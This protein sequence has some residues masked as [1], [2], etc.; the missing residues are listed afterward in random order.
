MDTKRLKVLILVNDLLRG[1][2]QRI[3]ADIAH[4]IDTDRFEL[5]VAYLKPF[6]IF[7]TDS[8]SLLSEIEAGHVRI[9]CVGGRQKASFSEFFKLLKLLRDEKPDV[10][11]TF[12]PYASILG[13]VAG[14]LAGVR[15]IVSTQCNASVSY[16]R[17]IYWLDKLTLP[18][19]GAWT[20]VTEGIE[21]EYGGSIAHYSDDAWSLGRRHF[22][23][24]SAVNV[25]KIR[26]IFL[27]TDRKQKRAEIGVPDSARE[28]MM[29]ARL[30][31]WKGQD[32]LIKSLAYLPEDTHVVLA[33][34]GPSHEELR[35][36]ARAQGVEARVHFLGARSDVYEILATADVFVQ[37]HKHDQ[38][39]N[40]WIGPN[41]AQLEAAAV[42]VP[43]VSTKNPFIEGLL[44]DGVTGTLCRPNDP[45]DL[46][47]AIS[48]VLENREAATLLA[49]AAEKRVQERYSVI[50]MTRSYESLYGSLC[51]R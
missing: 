42:G 27:A 7:S 2:A 49:Q 47:R 46:A 36:L 44:E 1:G 32:E 34:W 18:L 8:S 51:G 30:I 11:H 28:V 3:I 43:S 41:I 6:E 9:V 21:K 39:G 10:I 5:L 23:V 12:L 45:E 50:A 26:E 16:T 14:R 38:R 13:R 40:I 17:K 20:A 22:T 48:W 25:A 37:A 24:P 4:T 31:S 35:A 19:A 15:S 29:T 33:G